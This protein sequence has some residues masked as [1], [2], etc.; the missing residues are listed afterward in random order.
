MIELI[1]TIFESIKNFVFHSMYTSISF[2]VNE[3]NF[4]K[5]QIQQYPLYYYKPNT[6]SQSGKVLLQMFRFRFRI[7]F[8]FHSLLHVF[9]FYN[10]HAITFKYS[11]T[12]QSNVS[13][14]SVYLLSYKNFQKKAYLWDFYRWTNDCFSSL[15]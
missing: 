11:V 7:R 8:R 2:I 14:S 5:Q 12:F 3:N 4:E 15:F 13:T 6:I 9:I 1:K 10:W